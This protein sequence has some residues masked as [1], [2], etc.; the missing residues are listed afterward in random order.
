[1]RHQGAAGRGGPVASL[2]N[3]DN[4]AEEKMES[5]DAANP[6]AVSG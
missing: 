3:M 2:K 6:A 5:D 1:L 4:D